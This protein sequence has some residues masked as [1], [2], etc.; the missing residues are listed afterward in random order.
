MRTARTNSWQPDVTP[1]DESRPLAG[2]TVLVTRA[3]HQA[4][5]LVS[6]LEGYGATVLAM[7]VIAIIDPDDWAPVD[8]A[9]A[10]LDTYDWV[11]FTSSNAVERFMARVESS[12]AGFPSGGDLRVAAVGPATAR[13]CRDFGIEPDFIPEE[14][15]AEGLIDG[16]GR[17]GLG[18]GTRVL[19]PR[20]LR[21][22]EVLP[23]TL[24]ARG[25]VVDVVA[26]Y[27]TVDAAP[28][29]AMVDALAAGRI[30]AVT[31]TSPS[32]VRAFFA[33]IRSTAADQAA[34]RLIL[35]SIGPV[36]SAALDELGLKAGAEAPEHTA[37]GLALALAST[38]A[39]EQSGE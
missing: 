29:P 21:A 39:R 10:A 19:V 34:R 27:R 6:A 15:I 11:V 31:F 37:S 20:A 14:A 8:R 7:P 2:I 30:D 38:V 1:A 25:A 22:R 17:L 33:A 4:A 3:R 28:D 12:G 5:K 9:I 36:T 13:S 32:T 18:A 26:V 23:E 16:F 24:R 35:A